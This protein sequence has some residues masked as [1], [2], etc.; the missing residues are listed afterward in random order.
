M[1][2]PIN[3][4]AVALQK[5]GE[6]TETALQ[7]VA[8]FQCTPPFLYEELKIQ[9]QAF[10]AWWTVMISSTVNKCREQDSCSLTGQHFKLDWGSE[11]M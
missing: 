2:M 1:P 10:A 8:S 3:D 5:Q 4:A 11:L 9:N 7:K 6:R